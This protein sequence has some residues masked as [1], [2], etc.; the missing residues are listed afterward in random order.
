[1]WARPG[2]D[3]RIPSGSVPTYLE[4]L[5]T[6]IRRHTFDAEG[7]RLDRFARQPIVCVVVAGSL[8]PFVI[9]ANPANP[10]RPSHDTLRMKSRCLRRALV[11]S[12]TFPHEVRASG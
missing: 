11:P 10:P 4:E 1:M 2:G 7:T 9:T 8:P 12:S 3:K 6:E 5:T